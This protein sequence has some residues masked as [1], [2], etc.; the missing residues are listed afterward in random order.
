MQQFIKP[1]YWQLDLN[2]DGKEDCAI[3]VLDKAKKRRGIL[4]LHQGKGQHFVMG[5]GQEFGSGGKNFAW[6][7]S[8]NPYRKT[9]AT[10]TVFAPSGD[11]VGGKKVTLRRPGIEVKDEEG[12][13][14]IIYWDGQKYNWIHQGE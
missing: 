5:A 11:I 10:Q 13:G 12:T 4:V 2:G 14:G 8:W 9:T 7:H 6:L 1:L 3:Q